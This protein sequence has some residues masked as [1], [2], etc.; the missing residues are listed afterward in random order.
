MSF[1]LVDKIKKSIIPG[2]LK[3]VFEGYVSFG[4]A[5]GTSIRPTAAAVAKR[6]SSS[7]QTV[8]RYT[9]T[10]VEWGFLIHELNEDGTYK[11]YCYPKPGVWAYVYR[12]SLAPLE[13]PRVVAAFEFERQ[14]LSKKRRAAGAQGGRPKRQMELFEESNLLQTHP[15]QIATNPINQF[16]TNLQKQ[17]ATHTI[18]SS[19]LRSEEQRPNPNL[20]P[21]VVSTTVK[22]KEE[23]KKPLASST[24]AEAAVVTPEILF[25]LNSEHVAEEEE[26]PEEKTKPEEDRRPRRLHP[27]VWTV[28]ELWRRRTGRSFTTEEA[29]RA[30]WLVR[31]HRTRVVHD[32]LRVT[33]YERPN[34]AK[35][36]WNKFEIFADHWQRNYA[37]YLAYCASAHLT[38]KNGLSRPLPPKT[39]YMEVPDDKWC[40]D[41][42]DK[43]NKLVRRMQEHKEGDWKMAWE[44]HRN[45]ERGHLYVVM[46]YVVAE[47]LRVD[48]VE[49]RVLLMEAVGF[50]PSGSCAPPYIFE[51]PALPEEK[52]EG[53]SAEIVPI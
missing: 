24:L 23:T 7:R 40:V 14:Q 10:L 12:A 39:K 51:H 22:E 4:N 2:P 36:R 9:P 48:E 47:Q 1:K 16:A 46:D 53:A 27:G 44:D 30:D 50:A 3:K 49:F 45:F 17:I 33:L 6:A 13:N 21:S 35:L 31:T 8:A 42:A 18:P 19:P 28:E 20:D 29:V 15:K 37:E 25:G 52:P 43:Y 32:V 34:S 38:K 11:T 41:N 5:D 26:K